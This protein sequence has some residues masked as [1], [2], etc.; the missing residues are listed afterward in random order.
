M[1]DYYQ[2]WLE[3]NG[4]K[5]PEPKLIHSSH[6]E[7]VVK[8]GKLVLRDYVDVYETCNIERQDR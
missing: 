4:H 2:W 6:L 3:N 5:I 8:D 1:K 7:V